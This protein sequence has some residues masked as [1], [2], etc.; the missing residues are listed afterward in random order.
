MRGLDRAAIHDRGIPSLTLMERAGRAVAR[1]VGSLIRDGGLKRGVLLLAGVGNN[2]GDAFVAA[3][4]LLEMG[5]DARTV[6]LADPEKSRGDARENLERLRGESPGSLTVAGTIGELMECSQCLD[7]VDIVVDGILGT[8][9]RGDVRGHFAEAIFFVNGS[10]RKVVSIDIPSGLDGDTGE[11]H[12]VCVDALATV[13]MGLPKLGLVV[14]GG[15]EHSGRIY[16]ADIGIPADLAEEAPGD[17]ELLAAADLYTLFAHRRRVAHKGNFGHVLVVAGS[18]GMTG[19]AALAARGALRAGAGL[20]T[21]GIP[22]DLN[23]L[24]EVK[25]TEAM[26]VPLPQTVDGSLSLEAAEWILGAEEKFDAVVL[27]PGLSTHP[28]TIELV[29][30]LASSL[31]IPKVID[32]DGLNAFAGDGEAISKIRPP[33]VLTPH[34]GEM[35]R[36]VGLSAAEVQADRV[37]LAVDFAARYGVTVALKGAATVIADSGDLFIN[38]TGNPGMASGGMGDVLAGIL[39]AYLAH[40]MSPLDAVK[41]GVFIHGAAGDLAALRV[42]EAGL[43]A[44]DLLERIPAVVGRLQS[45]SL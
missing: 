31:S 1:V 35:G 11:V 26:T 19:A 29:R 5:I 36:L 15:P 32:A 34:P 14:G 28:E 24:M 2:G 16:V 8:G 9:I 17:L 33:A 21:V 40:G 4:H 37:G 42:G 22:E 20:V 43:I 6:L 30:K 25:L 23:D 18:T 44:S 13:T 45:R 3:R 7:E 39:G 10:N 38:S 41:S 12:G 27:G